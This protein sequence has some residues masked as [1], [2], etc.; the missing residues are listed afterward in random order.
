MMTWS[1]IGMFS[2]LVVV[3]VFL[4]VVVIAISNTV[5]D[6]AHKRN[7]ELLER[8]HEMALEIQERGMKGGNGGPAY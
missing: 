3:M 5:K 4:F 2:V 8:Q 6:S 7:L 1:S